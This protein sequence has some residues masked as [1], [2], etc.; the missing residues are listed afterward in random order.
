MHPEIGFHPLFTGFTLFLAWS[1]PSVII[2]NIISLS[3]SWFSVGKEAQLTATETAL[4][5]G[6]SWN[7]M[8]AVMPLVI[9]LAAGAVPARR[10]PEKFGTGSLATKTALLG[11]ASATLA[12][13]AAVRAATILNPA[14]PDTQDIL[15]GK[16]LFYTTGFMLEIFVVALYAVARI[17]LLFHIPDGSSKPGDYSR[18]QMMVAKR[19]LADMYHDIEDNLGRM[20]IE[21]ETISVPVSADERSEFVFAKLF[22]NKGP[23][24]MPQTPGDLD[25]DAR[26]V[27]GT[28]EVFIPPRP[29]RVSRRA[30]MMQ[31]F[32]PNRPWREILQGPY[33]TGPLDPPMQD[34]YFPPEKTNAVD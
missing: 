15:F 27:D 10:K 20:G 3:V 12:V 32:K 2:I 18:A 13:G 19:G 6:A 14:D 17:D 8:L 22:I 28:V 33:I 34:G 21:Y 4:K 9:L 7:V 16:A 30:T 5:F 11:Y 1:V 29:N 24:T 23:P 31:A 26:V 25:N